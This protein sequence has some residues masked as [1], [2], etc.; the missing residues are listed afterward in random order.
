MNYLVIYN[1]NLFY[2]L[3]TPLLLQMQKLLGQYMKKLRNDN[4]ILTLDLHNKLSLNA[5]K[6]V[7]LY[8]NLDSDFINNK[9]IES[10][11]L[12]GIHMESKLN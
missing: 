1:L 9:N 3:M 6:T 10:A 11:K 7:E 4:N 2:M 12:L 8:F 5:T